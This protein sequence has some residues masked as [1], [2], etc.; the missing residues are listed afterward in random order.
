MDRSRENNAENMAE[1]GR[2]MGEAAATAADRIGD[3]LDQGRQ[4]IEEM[5]SMVVE[6]T[7]EC[8]EA[9]DTFVRENPWRA[10]GVAAGVGVIVGLL[11]ARR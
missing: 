11:L 6:R 4:T 3:S 7:R 8:M 9:T 1:A 10:V 5:Q 2:S